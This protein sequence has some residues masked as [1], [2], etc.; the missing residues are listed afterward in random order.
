M[1]ETEREN[2]KGYIRERALVETDMH[3]DQQRLTAGGQG[4]NP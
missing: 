2:D 3:P 1:S 4:E